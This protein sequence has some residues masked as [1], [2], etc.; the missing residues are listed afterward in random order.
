MEIWEGFR[1]LGGNLIMLKYQMAYQ[2]KDCGGLTAKYAWTNIYTYIHI[3]YIEEY[4]D[5]ELKLLI[6][7]YRMKPKQSDS[8]FCNVFA[9]C[10]CL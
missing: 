6:F 2:A 9:H 1:L 5:I 7:N 4:I 8:E 10:N 3:V